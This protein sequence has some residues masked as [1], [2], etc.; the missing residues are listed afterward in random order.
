LTL[1]LL[2]SII[3]PISIFRRLLL[4]TCAGSS[5][6]DGAEDTK[7]EQIGVAGL[8][9]SDRSAAGEFPVGV[10]EL[11]ILVHF[12]LCMFAVFCVWADT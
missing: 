7:P 11:L 9:V 1:I 10:A 2:I 3:S 5:G 12:V 8:Q 6:G 4:T